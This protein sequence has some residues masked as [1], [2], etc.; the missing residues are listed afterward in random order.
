MTAASIP[1]INLLAAPRRAALAWRHRLRIWIGIVIAWAFIVAAAAAVV[2]PVSTPLSEI[3]NDIAESKR[4]IANKQLV[5]SD[6]KRQTAAAQR[7]L[8]TS[9]AVGD[10][11]DWSIML[12]LLAAR[13]GEDIVL[14]RCELIPPAPAQS[15]AA[16]A[17]RV[18]GDVADSAGASFVI[19]GIARSQREPPR[20]ALAIEELGLFESV[21]LL[22]MRPRPAGTFRDD[23]PLVSFRVRC[24][25]GGRTAR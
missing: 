9:R 19:E 11:P 17:G 8:E 25:I 21:T 1:A 6:L 15:G 10:H 12:G 22:E 7:E 13:C 24:I 20:F 23:L 2:R 16:P 4:V 14:E 18:A 5:L 3:R